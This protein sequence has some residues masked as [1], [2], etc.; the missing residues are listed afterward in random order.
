ME[1]YVDSGLAEEERKRPYTGAFVALSTVILLLPIFFLP[2]PE[3][4]LQFTKTMLAIT[5]TVIAFVAYGIASL[6]NGR[7]AFVTSPLVTS[8]YLLTIGYLASSVFS[9][10]PS[11]SFGGYQLGADTFW[12]IAAMLVFTHLTAS[13]FQQKSR[14]FNALVLFLVAGWLVLLF[15]VVQVAF[16]APFPL[17]GDAGVGLVGRWSD[18]VLFA[19]LMAGLVLL[20]L[21]MLPLPKLHYTLLLAT[22]AV[23]IVFLAASN[24]LLA[25]IIFGAVSL[26]ITVLSLARRYFFDTSE[27]SR[28]GFAASLVGLILALFF[29]FFG[30]SLA[31]SLQ[32]VFGVNAFDVRPSIGATLD[33]MRSVYTGNPLVGTGPNTFADAW[34]LH[35]DPSVVQTPFWN[36]IFSTGS[37]TIL[38]S[39]AVGGIVLFLGW[40]FFLLAFLYT[41]IRAL[42]LVDFTERRSYVLT[43]LTAFGAAYLFT[44]HLFAVPSQALTTLL[45]LFVG[46][47]VASL[48]GTPLVRNR[49]V[50]LKK[51]PRLGFVLVLVGLV[52]IILA[53][54][55]E[56]VAA[57]K[58]AST[59]FHNRAIAQA[60]SGD[61]SR[62]LTLVKQ[63]TALDPQDRYFRTATLIDIQNVN[64]II[65]TGKSDADT[66]TA[67]Q[68]AVVAAI[69]DSGQALAVRPSYENLFTRALVYATVVP[70]NVNGAAENGLTAFAEAQKKNPS[71]P[72][73]DLRIAQIHA[74]RQEF[75]E[76]RA[77]IE[78]ALQKKA[79]YTDAI[80]LR[81]QIELSQG[82][83]D[84]A[85]TAVK[86]AIYF[87]P[88][89]SVLLYQLG[90]LSLQDKSFDDAALALELSLK[91]SPDFANAMFF[92]SQAYAS[93]GRLDEAMSMMDSVAALNQDNELVKGYQEAFKRGENPFEVVPVPPEDDTGVIE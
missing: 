66:Q 9:S 35:R 58:Y 8:L 55:G 82:N 57:K 32:Q 20:A 70:L 61:L 26:G 33:I 24:S 81:A 29:V 85:I 75:D 62:A 30:S 74:A 72:E 12:Y 37:G 15:Q 11:F 50:L 48:S 52:A 86:N 47:F 38:S 68:N 83:L 17:F 71:G 14:I 22:Y 51:T 87:E 90:I 13:V 36:V 27:E 80:L 18:F 4:G 41:L 78:A 63:A 23:L 6:K 65:S 89:N 59:I 64:Q 39:I 2:I 88:N 44:I 43:M 34:L 25:W 79:D 5:G 16:G 7:I 1:E 67:F 45:F 73:A 56:Y 60:N 76:A 46:L 54:G 42:L 92:L 91:Q 84:E 3:A 49:E 10:Q 93:L 77:S 40:L 19:G 53:V 28:I 21:E 69:S 31:V